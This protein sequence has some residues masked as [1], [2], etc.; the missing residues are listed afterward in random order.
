MERVFVQQIY[1]EISDAVEVAKKNPDSWQDV[2]SVEET[3]LL[4]CSRPL[5]QVNFSF[6][7][8]CSL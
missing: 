6:E 4:K 1:K 8:Q 7:K 3:K 2:I 5:L